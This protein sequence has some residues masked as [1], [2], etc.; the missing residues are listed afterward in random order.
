[1]FARAYGEFAKR[2]VNASYVCAMAFLEL[3]RLLH[4]IIVRKKVRNVIDSHFLP[5]SKMHFV[6]NWTFMNY[7]IYI[8]FMIKHDRKYLI[9]HVGR[10][11]YNR[12]RPILFFIAHAYIL[13]T[14]VATRILGHSATDC[15]LDINRLDRSGNFFNFYTDICIYICTYITWL[16]A[17]SSRTCMR[18]M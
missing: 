8:D 1:M 16:I 2:K 11:E 18:N 4:V 14:L 5:S 9:Y 7:D 17:Q 15:E 12:E 13:Y 6:P 3:H 10:N